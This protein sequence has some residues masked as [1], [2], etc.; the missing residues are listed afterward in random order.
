MNK[1]KELAKLIVKYDKLN[2]ELIEY[3]D[4]YYDAAM[5]DIQGYRESYYEYED[6]PVLLDEDIKDIKK[7]ISA[8]TSILNGHKNLKYKYC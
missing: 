8:L 6:E 2:E 7:Q 5:Y 4:E 3:T 1:H